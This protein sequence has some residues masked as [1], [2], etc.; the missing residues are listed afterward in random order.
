MSQARKPLLAKKGQ[1]PTESDTIGTAIRACQY[2]PIRGNKMFK[3]IVNEMAKENL[4]VSR[5]I[6][7]YVSS[8]ILALDS[9]KP[10]DTI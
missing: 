9:L 3:E 8:V 1:A 5:L 2:G 10:K 7:K 4:F 6:R